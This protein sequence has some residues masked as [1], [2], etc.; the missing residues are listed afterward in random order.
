MDFVLMIQALVSIVD[1]AVRYTPPGTAIEVRAWW[2]DGA[3]RIQ[4]AD[5]GPGVP[6]N[7]VRRIFDKFHRIRRPGDAGGVGLG[8]TIAAGIVELHGGGIVAE[9]RPGGGL[10]V[11]V[12]L[13]PTAPRRQS[14]PDEA[15]ASG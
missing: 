9:N 15:A 6:P 2:E 3:V 11:T 13:P 7:E 10:A 14:E 1:N 12:V 8:L 5:R 4:I